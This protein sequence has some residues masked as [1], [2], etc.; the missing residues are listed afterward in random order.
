MI[1]ALGQYALSLLLLLLMTGLL[2][3]GLCACKGGC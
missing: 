2:L 1:T 3:G